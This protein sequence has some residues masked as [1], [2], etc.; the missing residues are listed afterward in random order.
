MSDPRPVLSDPDLTIRPADYMEL[1]PAEEAAGWDIGWGFR[2]TFARDHVMDEYE[3]GEPVDL[4]DRDL[5]VTV[6][7]GP[8]FPKGG[9]DV[10]RVT[11]AQ[12]R[13]HAEHLV[14]LADVVDGV[15]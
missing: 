2:I 3:D 10:R 13:K 14:A 11:T 9:L 5:H 8:D 4:V 12:L 6:S 7:V 15:A 1:E